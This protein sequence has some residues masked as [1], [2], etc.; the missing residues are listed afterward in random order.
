MPMDEER[1]LR[2]SLREQHPDWDQERLDH[3]VYGRLREQGWKP[4]RE[5]HSNGN[6]NGNGDNSNGTSADPLPPHPEPVREE[7][8]RVHKALEDIKK[9]QAHLIVRVDALH[10][11]LRAQLGAQ[12]T[13]GNGNGSPKTPPPAQPQPQHQERHV[14]RPRQPVH[15]WF[16]EIGARRQ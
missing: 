5:H 1:A 12:A 11:Q 7:L 3:V 4:E 2:A 16:R 6:G 13:A 10:G 9:A 8:E 15:P 14:E